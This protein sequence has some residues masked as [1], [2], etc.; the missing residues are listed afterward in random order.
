M[1]KEDSMKVITMLGQLVVA[2]ED[3]FAESAF[4]Y[5]A[6][7]GAKP[8]A[9]S[10]AVADEFDFGFLDIPVA[11][12][13]AGLELVRVVHQLWIAGQVPE[14]SIVIKPRCVLDEP[15]QVYCAPHQAVP[16]QLLARAYGLTCEDVVRAFSQVSVSAA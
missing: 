14:V 2:V 13:V 8:D 16:G 3:L 1:R 11:E 7:L 10:D 5:Y 4:A 6:G 12:T 9:F 15:A